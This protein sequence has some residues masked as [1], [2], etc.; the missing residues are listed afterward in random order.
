MR[1]QPVATNKDMLR[2]SK[3]FRAILRSHDG[4]HIE[5]LQR[6]ID[7]N[8][9]AGVTFQDGD[10]IIVYATRERSKT[11]E[12]CLRS[13]RGTLKGLDISTMTL[14]GRWL[15]LTTDEVV[16]FEMASHPT[17]Q[18][19]NIAAVEDMVETPLDGDTR[20]IV[21]PSAHGG[22]TAATHA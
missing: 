5:V 18:S 13:F 7:D 21:L 16:R 22:I 15:S 6:W 4:K 8:C 3:S 20:T 1:I 9:A 19:E 11:K 10:H 2:A 14:R 12:G 17:A